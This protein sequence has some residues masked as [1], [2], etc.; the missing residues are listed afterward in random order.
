MLKKAICHQLIDVEDHHVWLHGCTMFG[1][2]RLNIG[3]RS[4]GLE[5]PSPSG[6]FHTCKSGLVHFSVPNVLKSCSSE[7]GKE[8]ANFNM[9]AAI[10]NPSDSSEVH[11][12]NDLDLF[13]EEDSDDATSTLIK[14]HLHQRAAQARHAKLAQLPPPA[15]RTTAQNR[16]AYILAGRRLAPTPL[17]NVFTTAECE[18]VLAA[19]V[20]Y[21]A[22]QGGLQT[23]RHEKFATTDVPVAD[24]GGGVADAVRSWVQE[25]VLSAMAART[26]FRA[27]GAG[28]SGGDDLGLKDL[29]VVCYCGS[30]AATA[31]SHALRYPIPSKQASLAVHSDGCLMSFSL[32]LNHHDAFEGGGTFFK[33]TGETFHVQQGGLLMHDAGLERELIWGA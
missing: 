15:Q 26:G 21:V 11:S 20:D 32:L 23:A 19:V 30:Q 31:A 9:A 25:R 33:G 4:L 28:G 8:P 7:F 24:L 10:M 18:R 2:G 17:P 3:C 16:T 6:I 13:G 5:V 29:F 12:D 27:G 14:Q 1:G 22:R